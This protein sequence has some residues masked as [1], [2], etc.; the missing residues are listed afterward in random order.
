MS[1]IDYVAAERQRQKDVE[2]WTEAHDDTH[3]AG[4][5][6]EAAYSY[7]WACMPFGVRPSPNT[8]PPTYWPWD[9]KWWKPRDKRR[10]LVRAAALLVA[11][12]ERLDRNQYPLVSEIEA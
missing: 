8:P 2:G 4:E 1:A 5:M 11:E 12:I 3:S 10:N 9:I 7:I 6:M